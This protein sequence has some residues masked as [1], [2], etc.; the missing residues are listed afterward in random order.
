MSETILIRMYDLKKNGATLVLDTLLAHFPFERYRI[1][2]VTNWMDEEFEHKAYLSQVDYGYFFKR[3]A[4]HI[5][6]KLY[7]RIILNFFPLPLYKKILTVMNKGKGVKPDLEIAFSEHL[8]FSSGFTKN[9]K[10]GGWPKIL[11]LHNDIFERYRFPWIRLWGMRQFDKVVCVTESLRHKIISQKVMTM[12]ARLESRLLTIDNPVDVQRVQTLALE[13]SEG[14]VASG[15]DCL[16][17]FSLG[18]LNKQKGFD[19]LIDAHSVLM[20][21][22]VK[23]SLYIAGEGPERDAL[24]QQIQDLGVTESVTLLGFLTNPYPLLARCDVFVLSSR[25]EGYGLVLAEAV[26]LNRVVLSTAV[27]GAKE[28]LN[29]GEY[30][31]I[32]DNTDDGLREGMTKL[33]Q[34]SDLQAQ[35][36]NASKN[37]S[38][39]YGYQ[40]CLNSLLK[41]ID[42]TLA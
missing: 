41:L 25:Y 28:N 14:F 31:L 37:A 38:E 10:S 12:G 26:I 20:K 9:G 39:N 35:Y 23:H 2:L 30:G 36:K 17:V 42:D 13:E 24:E 7:Q 18:R 5:V 15:N 19:R 6:G 21:E 22:G 1:L 11:W 16:N 32:V 4:T 29:D 3:R 8:V 34:D 27:V 33:L 40:S